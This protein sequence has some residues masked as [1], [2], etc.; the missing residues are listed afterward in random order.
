MNRIVFLVAA[1]I[2]FT[3]NAL[4][5][6]TARG[7]LE[8]AAS[9]LISVEDIAI[10]V[11]VSAG[12]PD[13]VERASYADNILDPINAVI[14]SQSRTLQGYG[15]FFAITSYP[16]NTKLNVIFADALDCSNPSSIGSEYPHYFRM[17]SGVS[18]V[19]TFA[20]DLRSEA[21][22]AVSND[23]SHVNAVIS[24]N[25]NEVAAAAEKAFLG[26]NR[27]VG[28]QMASH[29]PQEDGEFTHRILIAQ[30]AD[31]I[32]RVLSYLHNPY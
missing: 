2:S 22:E 11:P 3:G 23:N 5:S 12:V 28:I 29:D 20:K 24:K 31:G 6:D 1:S 9:S 8:S 27:F 13:T 26:A 21:K 14:A 16:A 15:Y 7:S 32:L 19:S 18:A 4:A 17:Y 30:E 25:I 10:P